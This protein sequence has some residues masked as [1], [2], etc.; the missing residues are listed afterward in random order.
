MRVRSLLISFALACAAVLAQAPRASAQDG[1]FSATVPVVD[2][3]EAQRD[4]A[5]A[6]ALGSVLAR[7]AGH[8]VS[9]QP[10]YGDTLGRAAS[11]VQQ[12]RYQRAGAGASQPFQL[13]V[14]FDPAA[15]RRAAGTLGAVTWEGP[16]APV[17]LLV[18]AAD[19]HLLDSDALAPLAQAVSGSG[20]KLAYPDANAPDPAQVGS[21]D[22]EA[23]AAIVRQYHT[24]MVLTGSVQ[25]GSTWTLQA[26]GH[27]QSW[28][29]GA[30]GDA[31]LAAVGDDLVR[32]LSQQ[33]ASTAGSGGER[34]VWISG[35]ASAV[36]FTHVL[37]VL[38]NQQ[39]VRAVQPLSAEGDGVLL[40]LTT[41]VPPSGV[42]DALTA[43]GTMLPAPAH[44]GAESALRWLQ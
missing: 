39:G 37:A 36:D 2:T 10:G 31:Q 32:R 23:L 27:T 7:V 14:S 21:G 18:Q 40:K 29:P 11:M 43:A 8:D 44:A 42:L 38:G 19:G 3:S 26:A 35:I 24:G 30:S 33:L 1:Q 28:Q 4:H 25:P 17:L 9:A 41:S 34:T 15:V 5:F 6:V 20:L 12:Y 16:D 22:P 13:L